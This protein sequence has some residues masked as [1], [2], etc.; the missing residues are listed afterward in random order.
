MHQIQFRLE[1]PESLAGFM[2]PTSKERGGKGERERREGSH[3]LIFV[4]LRA[5][6]HLNV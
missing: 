3:L 4:G 6:S 2:G 5:G 1:L